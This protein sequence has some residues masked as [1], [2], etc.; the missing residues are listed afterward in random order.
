[1]FEDKVLKC[2]DCGCDFTFT[3]GEQEFY[4]EK[5]F[6]NEPTRCKE[7]RI[8]RKNSLKQNREMF[9][10]TCAACGGVA[11]VPFQPKDD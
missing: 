11:R 6:Q 7:C 9:E 1:M 5:G 8:A 2:V 10:T 4:Q 3:A